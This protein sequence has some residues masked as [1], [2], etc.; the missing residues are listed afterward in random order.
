MVSEASCP[1]PHVVSTGR[2][3]IGP[4]TVEVMNLSDGQRV[5]DAAGLA[6][7][8]DWLNGGDAGRATQKVGE[9]EDASR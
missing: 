3:D 8:L 1:L 4:V 9:P 7:V 2:L 5:V 6:A